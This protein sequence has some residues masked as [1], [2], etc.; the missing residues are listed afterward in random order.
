MPI[1]PGHPE[2]PDLAPF[3]GEA[4]D[5]LVIGA[6]QAGLAVAHHLRAAGLRFLVVDG[7]DEVGSAW[8]N[9]WDSLTLFTPAQ[10]DG[11]PSLA[12]PAAADTYPTA[13]EVAD[14]LRA[15]ATRFEL[16]VLLNTRVTRLSRD[17][18]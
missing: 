18:D 4:L 7:A 17:G 13:A 10:Y 3:R 12:F 9:R 1:H 6:G 5:V 11:L 14:Y 15:Y 8:R 2:I 16:P